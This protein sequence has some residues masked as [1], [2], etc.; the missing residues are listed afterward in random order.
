MENKSYIAYWSQTAFLLNHPTNKVIDGSNFS[1]NF[2]DEMGYEKEEVAAI[3]SLKVG[4]LWNSSQY[5]SLHTVARL[6]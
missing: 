6:T 2:C 5:G 3:A 4:E 1:E